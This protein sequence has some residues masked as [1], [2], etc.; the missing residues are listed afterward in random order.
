MVDSPVGGQ[1][2]YGQYG[3]EAVAYG[4]EAASIASAFGN[5]LS[6]ETTRRNGINRVVGLGSRN[7]QKLIEG[8]YELTVNTNFILGT[9]HWMAA[10]LG[11]V[12]DTGGGGDAYNHTYS[13]A[14]TLPS[15]TIED[16]T[17]LGTT[18]SVVKYL[19]CK[20]NE[21]TISCNVG[22][23]VN[24][25]LEWFAKTET[26]GSTLDASVASDSEE[27]LIF[28]HG[29]LQLPSGTT[30][31][32]VQSVDLT[33]SNN[34]DRRYGLGSRLLQKLIEG[35]RHYTVRINK[36][37]ENS[38]DMLE[39]FYGG[40]A[41]PSATTIAET[42][43][44][45]LIYTNGLATTLERSLTVTITGLKSDEHSQNKKTGE[46]LLENSTWFG[47]TAA[48]IGVDMTATTPFS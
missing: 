15:V 28:A 24:V 33:I 32:N 36:T 14:N 9:S 27:P 39:D 30:F 48:I 31:V 18:D 25:K 2:S 5:G 21:C 26:E 29:S 22:E 40:V 8:T 3:K 4:T 41:G 6:I 19:G 45:I 42:A 20:V 7:A 47:R 34:L 1:S 38:T 46:V 23:P 35:E 12:A 17:D 16:G 43:T 44:L 11:S 37:F 13:E 10:V